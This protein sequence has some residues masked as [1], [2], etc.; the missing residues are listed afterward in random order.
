MV[1]P[2]V[3]NPHYLKPGENEKERLVY[4]GNVSVL[5]DSCLGVSHI[6][7]K[8]DVLVEIAYQRKGAYLHYKCVS[9]S[10][11]KISPE[12]SWEW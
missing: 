4:K 2:L 5:D 11:F 1:A 6:L 12:E 9:C 7:H 3:I 10:F 8:K